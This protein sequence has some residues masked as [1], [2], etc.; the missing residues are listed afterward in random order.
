[1][2]GALGLAAAASLRNLG[3][4][5]GG[6]RFGGIGGLLRGVNRA[7]TGLV[8]QAISKEELP[9]AI[10]GQTADGTRANPFWVIVSPLSR[11]VGGIPE[12]GGSPLPHDGDRGG[13]VFRRLTG[14]AKRGAGVGAGA[15]RLFGAGGA[16]TIAGVSAIPEA[17]QAMY[18]LLGGGG[19]AVPPGHPLLSK[20]GDPA[21]A[22]A[23]AFQAKPT[24]LEN[25][26]LHR[27]ASGKM[28]A[29]QAERQLAAVESLGSRRGD[30][31]RVTV[32]GE[33]KGHFTFKLVDKQGRTILVQEE[34][35]VPVRLWEA[36]S[37]FPS[38]KGKPGQRRGRG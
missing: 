30:V 24:G 7:E 18:D 9:S 32:Q 4:F 22:S 29:D 26:I 20:F 3:I 10:T 37:S 5:R 33:A 15:W 8:S 34:K 21:R 28:N 31:Q 19:R 12:P 36:P 25:R 6:G 16:A 27:F 38:A 35:G 14:L 1:M 2:S 23:F 11:A 13:G 17:W